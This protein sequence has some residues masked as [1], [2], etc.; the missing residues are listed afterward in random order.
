MR[1]ARRD[2]WDFHVVVV[3]AVDGA[4]PGVVVVAGDDRLVRLTPDVS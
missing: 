2:W 3:V 1:E 4:G